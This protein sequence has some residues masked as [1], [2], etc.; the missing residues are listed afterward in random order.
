MDRNTGTINL[1]SPQNLSLQAAF[2]FGESQTA[3]LVDSQPLNR[4]CDLRHR[5]NSRCIPL[6]LDSASTQGCQRNGR[7]Q[8]VRSTVCPI[9]GVPVLLTKLAVQKKSYTR[10]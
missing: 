3:Q 7:A 10:R 8:E 9:V 2:N 5:H 4:A 1:D 6:E